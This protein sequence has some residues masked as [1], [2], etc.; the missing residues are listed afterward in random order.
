[1]LVFEL[2]LELNAVVE[3]SGVV[4]AVVV[5]TAAAGLSG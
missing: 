3:A 5:E 2:M 1:M 4:A